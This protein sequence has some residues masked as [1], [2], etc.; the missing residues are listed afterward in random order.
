[1]YIFL[2]TAFCILMDRLSFS[3]FIV[4]YD[5]QLLDSSQHPFEV[6]I[7]HSGLELGLHVSRQIGLRPHQASFIVLNAHETLG[8]SIVATQTVSSKQRLILQI[9][10][11]DVDLQC[12]FSLEAHHPIP[13]HVLDCQQSAVGQDDIVQVPVSNQDSVGVLNHLREDVLDWVG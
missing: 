10:Q 2:T 9:G 13:G 3:S 11:C 4:T 8:R 5:L 12:R 1:M 6:S 7:A